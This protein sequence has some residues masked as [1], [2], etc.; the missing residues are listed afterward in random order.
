VADVNRKN[1]HRR[2]SRNCNPS[3]ASVTQSI[4]LSLRRHL[5]RHF[6]PPVASDKQSPDNPLVTERLRPSHGWLLQLRAVCNS[7]V[8]SF[9]ADRTRLCYSV[10]FVSICLL[11]V[12]YMNI[13]WVVWFHS[14]AE[15]LSEEANRKC[16][17]GNRM[18]MWPT[19]SR[20]PERSRSWPQYTLRAQ[21]CENSCW[22]CYLVTIATILLWLR[23]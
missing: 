21:Y 10:A 20:D 6:T 7:T 13:L 16:P 23:Q 22:R 5:Q 4:W 18:V 17:M 8:P 11:S 1:S 3:W 12:T 19:T 2:I 15:K 14:L 9:L